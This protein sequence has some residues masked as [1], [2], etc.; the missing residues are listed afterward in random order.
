MKQLKI[1]LVKSTIGTTRETKDTVK[2]LGLRKVNASSVHEDTASIRGMAFKVRH[3]IKVE[4]V[5]AKA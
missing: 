4:D 5:D 3:L 2:S 1:T